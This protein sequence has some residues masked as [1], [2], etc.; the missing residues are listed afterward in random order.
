M[1]RQSFDEFERIAYLEA[2]VAAL[3][4]ALR[5]SLLKLGDTAFG[6][7]YVRDCSCQVNQDHAAWN[8]ARALLRPPEP[9][10]EP[11]A[12]CG[13]SGWKRVPFGEGPCPECRGGR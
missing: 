10:P 9:K 1:T 2:R 5:W 4:A 6:A 13:G 11:C 8:Q 12:T 7:C 3:E